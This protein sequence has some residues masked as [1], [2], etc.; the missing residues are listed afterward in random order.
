MRNDGR[1]KGC[2]RG[3]RLTLAMCWTNICS[4][5]ATIHVMRGIFEVDDTDA[6]LLIDA[7]NVFNALN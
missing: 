2:G 5:A 6:V 3:K 7:S 1:Q 4:E